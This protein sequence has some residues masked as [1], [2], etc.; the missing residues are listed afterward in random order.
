MIEEAG[1]T[2]RVVHVN[3]SAAEAG[4]RAGHTLA[5]A[6]AVVP[7][8]RRY[9]HDPAGD[10]AQ[11][12]ALAVW[13]QCLSP[14]VQLED[15]RT[16]LVDVT[17]CQR[18]FGGDAQLLDRALA[19][20]AA[21][22]FTVRGAVADTAG[23]AWALA[24]AGAEPAIVV[25][26][27]RTVAALAPLPVEALRLE[28]ATAASLRAVGI[29][30]IEALLH[31][32]RSALAVRWGPGVLHRFEQALGD[33]PE[34]LTPYQPE[35]A[36]TS[37]FTWAVPTDRLEVL[38]EA[39]D[40]A[41]ER[42]CDQLD[43]RRRG[44]HELFVT[45]FGVE[46]TTVDGA[47]ARRFSYALGLSQPT[48]SAERLRPLLRTRIEQVRLPI[49]VHR[50]MLWA[51][52]LERLDDEQGELFDLD[53]Q[54]A[55]E[56]QTLVDRLAVQLG[57]GQV[58]GVE[59]VSDH[60]PERAYRYQPLTGPG[61]RP[62]R[63]VR[64]EP[65]GVQEVRAQTAPPLCARPVRLLPCPIAVEVSALLPEGPL[66]AFRLYGRR[67]V[68]T[69]SVGPERLETGWWRGRHVQRDY[70]RVETDAGRTVWVFRDRA[71]GRWYVH[72]WFD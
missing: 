33:C 43:R 11:L 52:R 29:E 2:L 48:R 18:L 42:F 14:V 45:L 64:T 68:V 8:L 16:L 32:P 17:G 72:G 70:Y 3:R 7:G 62:Q 39:A 5:H 6:Q 65:T 51:R 1:T 54:H 36:L 22:G 63:A 46:A 40:R 10:R 35:P 49:A 15:D 30:T 9:A 19:G 61:G 25:E 27:G 4:V 28:A 23:A 38:L 12:E 53:P 58:V 26:P 47:H 69:R 56:L 66:L 21:Q 41:L 71:L 13:A 67:H 34:P 24:Q 44:V 50:L 20:I 31:L 57:A 60:Q 55:R 37:T 59:P